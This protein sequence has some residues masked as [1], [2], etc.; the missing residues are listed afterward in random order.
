LFFYL[1]KRRKEKRERNEIR[2]K[3]QQKFRQ[4]KYIRESN[5]DVR[6]SIEEAPPISVISSSHTRE[7]QPIS[8]ISSPQTRE[9]PPIS[10]R[11]SSQKMEA[12]PISTISSTHTGADPGTPAAK[13]TRSGDMKGQ[14]LWSSG[15]TQGDHPKSPREKFYSMEPDESDD[16]EEFP[17]LNKSNDKV[18]QDMENH[19]LPKETIVTV[20]KVYANHIQDE[21]PHMQS[22]IT[23]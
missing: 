15:N 8:A 18:I 6:S 21:H 22:G 9:A 16:D 3:H 7:A 5:V 23:T 2:E 12:P 11:S 10:G 1:R 4:N 14:D 19:Q 20:E 17:P 13:T